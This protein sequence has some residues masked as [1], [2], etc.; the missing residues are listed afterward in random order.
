M[1]RLELDQCGGRNVAAFMDTIAFAEGVERFSRDDGY[2]VIVG[3]SLFTSYADHPRKLVPLARL[4]IRSSAAE[5][6]QFLIRTWDDL[7]TRLGTRVLP[8]FSPI[9]QDRACI[10]LLKQCG[11][12]FHLRAARF[13][14]A[15][16]AA[17]SLW[18][19]LPGA[20]Y[21]QRELTA[22][23]L[24]NVYERAHGSVGVA[25]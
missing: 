14:D 25:T 5:R 9:S 20:G 15:L 8:D 4:V 6:Y 21:G 1:T 22:E 16:T 18:A 17:R 13:C 23:T 7:R 24:R 3:G 10:A 2:D 19:S 11:A 12:H